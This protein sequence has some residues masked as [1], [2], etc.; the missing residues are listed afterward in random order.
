MLPMSFQYSYTFKKYILM[1]DFSFISSHT[2]GMI[3]PHYSCSLCEIDERCVLIPQY[4][5]SFTSSTYHYLGH[6]CLQ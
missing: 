4:K 3:Y 5:F 2:V 6:A 1:Q